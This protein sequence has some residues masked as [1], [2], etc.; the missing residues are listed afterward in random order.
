MKNKQHIV[1]SKMNKYCIPLG[2]SRSVELK[3]SL[4]NLHPV[5]DASLTGCKRASSLDFLP[6]ETFLWNVFHKNI[7]LSYISS[8]NPISILVK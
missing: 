5:R 3:M 6:S 8:L 7:P 2:M 1:V 4:E